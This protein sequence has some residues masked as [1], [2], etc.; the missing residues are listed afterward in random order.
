MLKF[1]LTHKGPKPAVKILGEQC[2]RNLIMLLYDHLPRNMGRM[3]ALFSCFV[4]LLYI[5]STKPARLT[6]VSE[7]SGY[8]TILLLNKPTLV[9]NHQLVRRKMARNS[10]N[11]PCQCVTDYPYDE[12]VKVLA[13]SC[14]CKLPDV[15]DVLT[16]QHFFLKS[17]LPKLGKERKNSITKQGYRSTKTYIT[18]FSGRRSN[19][20]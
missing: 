4:W 12:N 13:A 8:F 14:L 20:Q 3:K 9:H 17:A 19:R 2:S 10:T 6:H 11:L 18:R 5:S 15:S 7:A 1:L 16:F